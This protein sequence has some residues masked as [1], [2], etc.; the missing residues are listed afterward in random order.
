[1]LIILY[2]G[3]FPPNGQKRN[4]ARIRIEVIIIKKKYN[5]CKTYFSVLFLVSLTKQKDYKL[6][7]IENKTRK[8]G[9]ETF[10]FV[11]V[12]VNT[13]TTNPFGGKLSEKKKN[14]PE[15]RLLLSNLNRAPLPIAQCA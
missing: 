9:N 14:S 13:N 8:N 2:K 10:G 7:R 3:N 11:F 4:I 15:L 5:F 6:K 12:P 1:M